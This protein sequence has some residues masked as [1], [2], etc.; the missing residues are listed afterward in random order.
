[1]IARTC[2]AANPMNS[3]SPITKIVTAAQ[4]EE[5]VRGSAQ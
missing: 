1:M 5:R 2:S 4:V 3:I